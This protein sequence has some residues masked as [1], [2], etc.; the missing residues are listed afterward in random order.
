M[1]RAPGICF[2]ACRSNSEEE[3]MTILEQARREGHV[4][5]P[6]CDWQTYDAVLRDPAIWHLRVTYDRGTLEIQSRS[7]AHERGHR[8][9]RFVIDELAVAF[10]VPMVAAGMTTLR[11]KDLLCGLEPDASYYT[12]NLQE[13]LQRVREKTEP[14]DLA[15]VQPPDLAIEVDDETSTLDR[16]GIYARLGVPEVW[17][18]AGNRLWVCRLQPDGTYQRSTVSPTFPHIPLDEAM[19]ILIRNHQVSDPS[20][21]R[22][23]RQWIHENSRGRPGSA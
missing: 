22:S 3:A 8:T 16:V 7:F 14:R 11:R 20:L 15:L 10:H 18:R 6:N 2:V 19:S 5:V 12:R 4:L 17:H 13:R 1:I 23:L 21:I 9:L